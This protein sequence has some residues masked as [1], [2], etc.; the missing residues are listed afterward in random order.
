MDVIYAVEPDLTAVEFQQLLVE[1]TLAERRPADDLARL[2]LMLRNA[3]LIVTARLDS[4][5]VGIARSVTDWAFCCY[6]SDLAVS[7]HA[8][9]KGIGRGLI[10]ETRR[11]CGPK[12]SIILNAAPGAVTFY[13][14]I[15][16]PR[17]PA[18]F[19]Y[20]RSE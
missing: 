12:V 9:G 7:Q 8:Q 13:E 17:H 20:G 11:L 10:E 14:A 16:M 5:L 2:E 18:S 15:G 1:S 3:N 4:K 19:W 6:L